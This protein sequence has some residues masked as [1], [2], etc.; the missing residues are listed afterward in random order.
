M[1]IDFIVSN[2][3]APESISVTCT[4]FV[5]NTIL[6]KCIR[7]LS[8]KHQLITIDLNTQIE[9]F[10]TVYVEFET[11]NVLISDYPLTFEKV[12]L[13]NFYSSKSILFSNTDCTTN[14]KHISHL[15][16]VGG[17]LRYEFLYPLHRNVLA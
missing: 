3:P 16:F 15:S 6:Y 2:Q 4:V 9:K 10:T 12:V 5:G 14:E 13:D 11:D 1:K 17:P 8:K 7:D